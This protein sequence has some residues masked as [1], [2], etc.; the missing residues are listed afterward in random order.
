[1]DNERVAKKI[2]FSQLPI[3]EKGES[4][5]S[6]LSFFRRIPLTISGELGNTQITVQ[7][8]L[9]L[10]EGSVIKLNKMAGE[11]AAILVNEQYLGEAEVVVVNDRFGLRVTSI[12]TQDADKKIPGE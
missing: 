6:E 1:M 9:H 12:G 10:T 2:Q 3:R 5:G 8:L 7:E 4:K 11:S